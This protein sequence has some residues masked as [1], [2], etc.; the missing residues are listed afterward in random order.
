MDAPA[1]H[2]LGRFQRHV[3]ACNNIS[4]PGHLIAFRIGQD[5]VGWIG[6]DLAR[7]LAFYPRD[8]HFDAQGVAMASRLRAP[9]ARSEALAV[10]AKGLAGAA[11]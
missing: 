6:T 2:D 8:F 7:A 4:S 9:G 5:Q 11:T 1:P 10:A 3:A